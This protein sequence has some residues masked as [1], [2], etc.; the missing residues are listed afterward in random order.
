MKNIWWILIILWSIPETLHMII[1]KK[2]SKIG[3]FLFKKVGL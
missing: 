3:E 1:T 2:C